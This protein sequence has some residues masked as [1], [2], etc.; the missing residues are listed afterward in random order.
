MKIGIRR[1]IN[2]PHRASATIDF[3]GWQKA[4]VPSAEVRGYE[5]LP[6]GRMNYT[7]LVSR[8]KNK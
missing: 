4:S 1:A 8:V 7:P 6:F 5:V 2:L 3:E